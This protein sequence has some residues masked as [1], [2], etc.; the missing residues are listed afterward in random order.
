MSLASVGNHVVNGVCRVDPFYIMI[1]GYVLGAASMYGSAL[2]DRAL[3]RH[4]GPKAAGVG[5][6]GAGVLFVGGFAAFMA[7]SNR[8]GPFRN[9]AASSAAEVVRTGVTDMK[10]GT[11]AL[12]VGGLAC[13]YGMGAL[14]SS[15]GAMD[16]LAS[17]PRPYVPPKAPGGHG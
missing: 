2:A 8:P 5:V 16:L 12:H 4:D 7:L 1:G 3:G 14:T 10:W 9:D 6:A 17:A 11:K 15:I 13:F